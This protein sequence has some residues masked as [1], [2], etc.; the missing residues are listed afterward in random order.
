MFTTLKNYLS[1]VHR[2]WTNG[3]GDQLAS[4][5]SLKDK[6]IMNR[7]LYVQNPENAVGRIL[8]SPIDEIIC[9]HLKVLY[10]LWLEPKDFMQAY[11]HQSQCIQSVVKMLQQLKEENWCLPVMYTVCLDLR[12]LAQHCEELGKSTK[13]GENFG[14]RLLIV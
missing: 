6:H 13:P 4:F 7:N 3:D 12:I 9:A 10:Y 2:A 11:K 1:N 14:K 8:E 5:I